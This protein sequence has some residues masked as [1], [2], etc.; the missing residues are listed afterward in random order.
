MIY[1]SWTIDSKKS[2]ESQ[3]ATLQR[4]T[5]GCQPVSE[6]DKGVEREMEAHETDI[7]AASEQ[8]FY[9]L[10]AWVSTIN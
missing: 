7:E 10:V 3:P 6:K 8:K 9:L 1:A 5:K 2:I 4:K